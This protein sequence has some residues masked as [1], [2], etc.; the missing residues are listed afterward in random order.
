MS[1]SVGK[2]VGAVAGIALVYFTGGAAA[3]WVYGVAAAVGAAYGDYVA[4]QSARIGDQGRE[5]SSRTIRS[6]K[7]PAHYL[8][9]RFA[10]G[11]V[12]TWVE[13][14]EGD[15]WTHLILALSEGPI[16]AVDDVLLDKKPIS[17]FEGNVAQYEL[18]VTPT[19][20]NAFMRNNADDWD[21]D[22]IGKGLS[23][24]RVSLQFDPEQFPNGLPEIQVI[25]RGRNDIWDPRTDERGYTDNPALILL[26]WLTGGRANVPL[27]EINLQSFIDAAN[28][29]D[30]LV[31]NPDGTQSKRY[32]MG[33]L[34]SDAELTPD[35]NDK[36]LATCNGQL[37]RI[38]G[39]LSLQVGAYYGPGDITLT[40]DMVIGAVS[41]AAEVDN[42]NAI[43]T[44]TGTFTNPDD[45]TETDF[46]PVRVD[47]WVLEDGLELAESMQIRYVLDPYQAQRLA[48]MHLRKRRNGGAMSIPMN[49]NGYRFRPGRVVNVDL[50]S[51]N[52]SGEFIVVDWTLGAADGCVVHLEAYDA[53]MFD[54]DVGRPYT[55]PVFISMPTGG[56]ETP[57]N[58]AFLPSDD[59]MV[60]Q[61][62]VTWTPPPQPVQYYGITIRREGE[63]VQTYQVP[64]SATSCDIQGLGPGQYVIEIYARGE[65]GRSGTASIPINLTVPDPP[66]DLRLEVSNNVIVCR[67]LV[68]NPGFG[69]E[70]EMCINYLSDPDF[71]P[72]DQLTGLYGTFPGLTPDTEYPIYARTISPLG[73]SEWF[74][75]IAR[76]ANNPAEIIPSIRD[77][78]DGIELRVDSLQATRQRVAD[79]RV[80]IIEEIGNSLAVAREQRERIDAV[81]NEQLTRAEAIREEQLT[82]ETQVIEV[83]ER[84]DTETEQRILQINGIVATLDDEIA[85]R[86]ASILQVQEAITDETEA[87]S[88]Q[89]NLLDAKI[90]DETSTRESSITQV[91]EAIVDETT[92]RATQFNQ[93]DAKIEDET[94]ARES[95]I[96][97][98]NE[99]IT[100]ET[101]ARA[102]QFNQLDSKIDDETSARESAITQTQDAITDESSTRA[103]Q[104]N[105]L[106]SR[107]DDEESTR[108]SQIDQV[109][110]AIADE[111]STRASAVQSL[112]AD[113]DGGLSATNDRIDSVEVD[114]DG[115]ARSI[116]A[117]QGQVND[118]ENNSSA[119]YDF[120]QSAQSTADGAV[121]SITAI[122]SRVENNEDFA[123]A[124]L[125]L[126]AEYE[127]EF[128]N[129]SARAALIT[130][131]NG[132]ITGVIIDD[133]GNER[134]VEFVADSVR[135]VDGNGV[136]KVYYDLD[137]QRY[138]FDGEIIAQSGFFGGT[139]GANTVTVG[140]VR[141]GIDFSSIIPNGYFETGDM[142][143]WQNP[144]SDLVVEAAGS[145]GDS[146]SQNSPFRYYL[147]D[148]DS[149][150]QSNVFTAYNVPVQ[151]PN[152]EFYVRLSAA[153]GGGSTSSCVW[154]LRV[155]FARADGSFISIG[156]FQISTSSYQWSTEE[157]V[158]VAP[159]DAAFINQIGLRQVGG[160]LR[161][162]CGG[163]EVRRRN[164]ASLI[165]K[166]GIKSDMVD[167]EVFTGR[168]FRGSYFLTEEPG[169]D[170]FG[171]QG[172]PAFGANN[173]L[174][175]WFGQ[176]TAATWNS[177]TN[178]PRMSGMSTVNSRTHETV[179]GDAYFGG[180]FQVGSLSNSTT[181]TQLQSTTTADLGSFGSNGGQIQIAASFGY[182]ASTIGTS[183]PV[184]EAATGILYIERYIGSGWQ[185][186]SQTPI[187][188]T[189]NCIQEGGD[190]IASW[191]ST[192]STTYTDN[193]QTTATR[194]Y[195]ARAVTNGIQRG[196]QNDKSLSIISTEE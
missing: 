165:V 12:L 189:Y 51:I 171:L 157:G 97:Q 23:F 79:A 144:S 128:G 3:P 73:K 100:D 14:D 174:F 68:N 178:E 44:L 33:A 99:A 80:N 107:I 56:I 131:N 160:N 28:V 10:N 17:E 183:C 140:S 98:V 6:S 184:S 122:E 92:A 26:W 132:R 192:A 24:I 125:I 150:S 120:V 169:S 18:T 86:Q 62:T 151:K 175:R 36:I 172:A 71:I 163:I 146:A 91:Q 2:I 185:T 72:F 41:G 53:A 4:R 50:P 65:L 37:I 47:E 46:P 52:M 116:S 87:R 134:V 13:Q 162:Y 161:G 195:R 186:V 180:T 177:S 75:Q 78:L 39:I 188:G 93:L 85:D 113:I 191:L 5:P 102:T 60:K 136:L 143:G 121:S 8:V 103:T 61:G 7:E 190:Y 29:C 147:L 19:E 115:N 35:V 88:T 181:N 94:S 152:E 118:P 74:S 156:T 104:F 141:S 96:T 101:E 77:E 70:F 145:R 84:V 173:N 138:V 95:S 117:V 176:K 89:F 54:D 38:G 109:N 119:L 108:Q 45:W 142:D 82:R 196:Q 158:I 58:L 123:A 21:E 42:A 16:D 110:Q 81:K 66:V 49:F 126:N 57:T 148:T 139:L 112:S 76:T 129:L 170:Y 67:P 48:N 159:P 40:E 27:E 149:S 133:D 187:T 166:G 20:A 1:R 114:V 137:D 130:D 127:D 164:G 32:T 153:S 124:Q 155:S 43:N 182:N 59:P 69:T 135:F 55:P 167:A 90:E 64:W 193:D 154:Q 194:R 11:G 179:N 111:A 31:E 30:E 63:A 34:I 106:S 105:G 15:P 22:V 9:G 83:N 25:G 168:V